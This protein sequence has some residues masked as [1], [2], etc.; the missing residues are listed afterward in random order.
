MRMVLGLMGCWIVMGGGMSLSCLSDDKA[1]EADMEARL[2]R[3]PRPWEEP[4]RRPSLEECAETLRYW[5]EKHAGIMTLDVRGKT[6]EDLPIL[7]ARVTDP[8]AKDEDKQ[9]VLI[10]GLHSGAERTGAT[11][12]LHFMEWLLGDSPEAAETRRKQIVLLMPIAN[13]WGFDKG[14]NANSQ[15]IDPYSAQRG[16]AWEIETLTLR[17]PEK[18]PEIAAF[19][20]VVDEF[21]PDVHADM[22]GVPLLWNG[23]QVVESA[24]TAYSNCSLRPW[25][26]RLTEAMIAEAQ[27]AGY[28]IDRGESDSQRL[29]WG[30][31]MAPISDRFWMGRPY[32]Y[33]STYAY[34]A[35]HTLP[36]T[37]EV[38]WEESGVARLKGLIGVGN[39]TWEGENVPGY[40]VNVMKSV[41][42]QWIV[43]WGRNAAERRRSRVELW[44]RQGALTPGILYPQTDCRA[45]LVVAVTEKGAGLM[46]GSPAKFLE[47]LGRLGDFNT[48]AIRAF[49]KSGP[50]TKLY[51]EKSERPPENRPIANGIALRLRIPYRNPDLCDLRL[52]GHLLTESAADGFQR[53]YGDGFTQVQVNIPPEKARAC[54]L[55]AVTCAYAPDVQRRYGWKPPKEVSDRI[56]NRRAK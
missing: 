40:P 17:E 30:P 14:S 4:V 47:N 19:K 28:G 50:E 5:A 18:A 53:W 36:V 35:C 29:F 7:L 2:S 11:A 38:G 37:A 51:F 21:K 39:G 43:S 9:I 3:M 33:T 23:Q 8:S 12:I 32:F 44:Q 45:S 22:H 46:D 55:L 41:V 48:A 13:P 24:G 6:K 31:D 56:E 25:D 15:G 34:T 1:E 26:W 20:S 27:K 54:D 49:V 10:T 16:K 42:G 52:N